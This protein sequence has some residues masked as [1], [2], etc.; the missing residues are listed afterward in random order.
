ML[1]GIDRGDGGTI[2][3]EAEHVLGVVRHVGRITCP[4]LRP[5]L[6]AIDEAPI[7]QRADTEA[8]FLQ[9]LATRRGEEVGIVGLAPLML[10]SEKR[11]PSLECASP[12]GVPTTFPVSETVPWW[13]ARLLGWRSGVELPPSAV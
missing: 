10:C 1:G 4:P 11:R 13:P 5:D 7:A 3:Q 8:G 2:H 6:V 9:E 12:A